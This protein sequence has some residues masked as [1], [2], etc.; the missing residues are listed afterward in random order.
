MARVRVRFLLASG[1]NNPP[2]RG[3]S[4]TGVGVRVRVEVKGRSKDMITTNNMST[5]RPPSVLDTRQTN[6]PAAR[7][8]LIAKRGFSC[9]A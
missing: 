8:T 7:P 3:R 2:S 5:H 6:M 1:G 4:T 9:R